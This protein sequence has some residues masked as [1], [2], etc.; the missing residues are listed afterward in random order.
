MKTIK[1][2]LFIVLT[3][4]MASSCQL[5][6]FNGPDAQVYGAIVD[7][8]TGELVAQEI[9][10]SGDAASIQVIEYGYAIRKVQKW[11]IKIN[12][13]YQN[14]LV[15]SGVYDII[16]ND[17]NYLKLDTLKAYPIHSGS[18]RLDFK[19]IPNIRIKESNVEK[20]DNQIVA[21]CK[22]EYGHD[23]G[24]AEKLALFIQSDQYPS[25]SF[26][27]SHV[28]SN[29]EEDNVCFANNDANET[30]VFSLTLDLTS[31]EGQKLKKGKKYF[32]RIGALPKDLGEG[33]QAKYNYSPV[34]EIQL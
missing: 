7:A 16:M 33:I 15:F 11:K 12:G 1:Q 6:N 9:G 34:F 2:L 4:L 31:E 30:K 20:V 5:D 29:I 21:T 18:N 26:N 32:A 3:G 27:L 14:D 22:L 28:E 10:T 19:V 17:G 24:K 23:T 13:E 25:Y 8:E